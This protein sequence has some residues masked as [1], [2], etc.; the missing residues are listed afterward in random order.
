MFFRIFEIR[1]KGTQMTSKWLVIRGCLWRRGPR[2]DMRRGEVGTGPHCVCLL[3]HLKFLLCMLI[4]NQK[5][6][7]INSEITFFPSPSPPASPEV[8][9]LTVWH[10]F[11]QI[12]L[13]VLLYV[14]VHIHM[15]EAVWSFLF[16]FI[17]H[18][19]IHTGYSEASF[20][21]TC[22]MYHV[23]ELFFDTS[24]KTFFQGILQNI[25]FFEKKNQRAFP[26][27]KVIW[28]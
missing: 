4:I 26:L 17:L 13:H 2:A 11:F 24:N 27:R 14:F 8:A 22:Y 20:F 6:V 12:L 10:V 7:K 9:L 18:K 21:P 16:G 19:C 1:L 3:C 5:W 25:K 15:Y 28:I 23:L